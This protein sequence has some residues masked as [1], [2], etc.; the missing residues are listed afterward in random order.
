M[1]KHNTYKSMYLYT[2][3]MNYD[4]KLPVY[5]HHLLIL[6]THSIYVFRNHTGFHRR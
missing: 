1:D 4:A 6:D 3:I 5:S 2:I